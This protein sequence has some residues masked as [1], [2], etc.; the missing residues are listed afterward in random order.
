[1]TDRW[2]S[3]DGGYVQF[4]TN[5]EVLTYLLISK[6]PHDQ[7]SVTE[8]SLTGIGTTRS[9]LKVVHA[10]D[11][12]NI[13]ISTQPTI[14]L[15]DVDGEVHAGAC[16]VDRAEFEHLIESLYAAPVDPKSGYRETVQLTKD[17]V[18]SYSD[19]NWPH[20]VRE[21]LLPE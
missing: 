7:V 21:V 8:A 9:F 6:L 14:I 16:P 20:E 17:F 5:N 3:A 18:N 10:S 15:V 13:S 2:L 19:R 4:A 12:R 11:S 1:M